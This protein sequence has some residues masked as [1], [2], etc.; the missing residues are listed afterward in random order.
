[1]AK[2]YH[3]LSDTFQIKV[4]KDDG[5][6]GVFHLEGLC[7][8]FGLTLGNGLRRVLFS[9][10]P[11][12]AI[13]RVKIKGVSHEF[14]TLPGLIEDI[15]ELTLNFKKVRFKFF[16]DE[17]QILIL[18]EKGEKE[19]KAG[20]IKGN[21][22]V[23][24]VNPELHLASLTDKKAELEIEFTVEKGL[25]YLPVS[26]RKFERL[27][28]GAIMIDAIFSPIVKVNFSVE[29]MR[30]GERTDYNRLKMEI[31]T[32]GSIT[33]TQALRKSAVILKDH[34]EKIVSGLESEEE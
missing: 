19:V 2:L 34:F 26:E 1:M 31:E 22:Q 30:V 12:A 15:I 13:T 3:H 14:T 10:L 16:A 11:G 8:G 24:I 9:S 17:P 21:S 29:N 27:P 23:E 7:G 32:D 4:V 20:D 18:K 6:A 5:E 33:P 25:G 28:V